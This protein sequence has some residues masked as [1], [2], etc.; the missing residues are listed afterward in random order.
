MH[1]IFIISVG[2]SSE[3]E[4]DEQKTHEIILT[5]FK[6]IKTRNLNFTHTIVVQNLE[7]TETNKILHQT[8]KQTKGIVIF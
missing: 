4:K 6:C 8:K 2:V 3:G 5:I 7:I 1:F